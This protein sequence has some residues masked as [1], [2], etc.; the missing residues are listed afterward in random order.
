MCNCFNET[1]ERIKGHLQEKLPKGAIEF[2]ADW[3]GRA[4]IMA[5]GQFAPTNP[6]IEYEY[7]NTKN[8]GTPHKNKRKETVSL[9]AS[10]C[11]FCGEKFE[12]PEKE[13]N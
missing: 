8:D 12:R 11:C 3:K 9:L 13:S 6:Q 7:R 10:H 5:E 1:L 4:F 2:E